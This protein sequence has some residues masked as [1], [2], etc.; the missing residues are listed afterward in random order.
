MSSTDLT[1]QWLR[2]DSYISLSHFNPFPIFSSGTR[3]TPPTVPDLL[4]P[5]TAPFPV[6]SSSPPQLFL[7]MPRSTGMRL[8]CLGACIEL[9]PEAVKVPPGP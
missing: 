5:Y 4:S 9:L 2:R 3:Q 8:E 6:R 7:C 1:A